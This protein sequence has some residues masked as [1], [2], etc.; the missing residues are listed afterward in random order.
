MMYQTMETS[1]MPMGVT[2]LRK[3]VSKMSSVFS[4]EVTLAGISIKK[5]SSLVSNDGPTEI[6]HTHKVR[7]LSTQSIN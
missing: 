5:N 7:K 6:N 2:P 3:P 1:P 4:R